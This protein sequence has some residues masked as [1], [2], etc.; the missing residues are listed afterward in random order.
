MALM[1]RPT[2]RRCDSES[3]FRNWQRFR[4]YYCKSTAAELLEK[5]RDDGLVFC[6][7]N[8]DRDMVRQTVPRRIHSE[9]ACNGA[10]SAHPTAVLKVG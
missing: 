5:L 9:R 2:T 10:C 6:S 8:S 4:Q 7:P 1:R 3:M